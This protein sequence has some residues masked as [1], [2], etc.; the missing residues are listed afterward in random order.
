MMRRVLCATAVT[1][2]AKLIVAD[3]PT[4]GMSKELAARAMKHFRDL[5]DEG[6]AVILI[7]HDIDLAIGYADK[8]AVFYAGTTVETAPVSDFKAEGDLRHPY[9]K[10][11][12]RAMPGNGFKP[13]A[14]TQP[15]TES[16]PEGCLYA[17]RCEIKTD[18]CISSTPGL[19][20]I[21]GGEV[22]CLY[23]D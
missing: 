9:S 8:V 5:A 19:R 14:G 11:L 20:E 2:G 7:T 10:A 16:L 17:P 12:W 4:P 18:K 1:S 6:A 13:T 21:R 22:C 15:Y 23:A 3:E